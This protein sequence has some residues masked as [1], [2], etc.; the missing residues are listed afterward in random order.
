MLVAITGLKTWN[1]QLKG[2]VEYELTRRLLKCTYRLREAVKEV[3]HP[4][5]FPEEQK[6]PREVES[7]MHLT[8]KELKHAG[9]LHAYQTRWSKISSAQ[10]DLH[11]ELLEAEVV[12]G[13]EIYTAFEPLFNLHKELFA[14][15][16]S[17]LAVAD[18]SLNEQSLIAWH[19]IR[20]GRRSVL[21]DMM[22]AVDDPFSD[23]VNAATAAIESFLKPHLAK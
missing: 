19:Q 3:R 4:M 1:R 13:R 5:M 22:G 15:I 21:Y 16:Q 11:T 8:G 14:D 9:L 2:S 23:E 18:P 10:D 7:T 12:W 17:Y 20:E 6:I